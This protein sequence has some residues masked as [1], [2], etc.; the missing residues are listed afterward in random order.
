MTL[1]RNVIKEESYFEEESVGTIFICL[2]K[3]VKGEIWM[4]LEKNPQK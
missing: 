2:S 4:I 3:E 1:E